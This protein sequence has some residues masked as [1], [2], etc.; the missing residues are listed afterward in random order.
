VEHDAVGLSGSGFAEAGAWFQIEDS[1]MI[2]VVILGKA[3][4][5]RDLPLVIT[6]LADFLSLAYNA[7]SKA[8]NLATVEECGAT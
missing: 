2:E 8:I 4:I 5:G 7:V 1:P 6:L 3:L